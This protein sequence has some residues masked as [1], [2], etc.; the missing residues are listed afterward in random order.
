MNY[1]E[2]LKEAKEKG[3]KALKTCKPTPV[4][5][6]QADLSDNPIGEP[7]ECEEGDCGGAYVT[8][9]NGKSEFV[10]WCKKNP[11]LLE[12]LVTL[13]KG[14]YKGYDLYLDHGDYRGQSAERYTAFADAFCEV[15]K[16]EGIKCGVRSYLS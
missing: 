3:M 13:S 8:G 15:L 12:G 4:T 6:V 1:L 10:G 11:S 14:V 7:E 9:L 16:R 2:T 5:F